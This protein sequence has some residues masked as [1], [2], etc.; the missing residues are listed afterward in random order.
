MQGSDYD[1]NLVEEHE[2]VWHNWTKFMFWSVLSVAV[3][4]M[5]MAVFLID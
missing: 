1:P 2:H 5:L 3:I 4:L